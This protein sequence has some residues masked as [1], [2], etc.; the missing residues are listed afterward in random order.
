M[1]IL[2]TK[3]IAFTVAL[4]ATPSAYAH[5][6]KMSIKMAPEVIAQEVDTMIAQMSDSQE[7][8]E[9]SFAV[10]TDE[11]PSCKTALYFSRI[12]VTF[13]AIANFNIGIFQL[14]VTPLIRLRFDRKP[15]RGWG[16]YRPVPIM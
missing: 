14:N 13:W 2:L 9:D 6:S 8:N 3:N 16:K 10:A 7:G 5:E 15:P 4:L 11:S 12:D 1:N